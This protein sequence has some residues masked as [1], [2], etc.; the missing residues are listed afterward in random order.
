MA[1]P[2]RL[3]VPGASVVRL[4]NLVVPPTTPPRVVLPV[5]CRFSA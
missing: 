2:L 5:L 4:A 3:V 1:P